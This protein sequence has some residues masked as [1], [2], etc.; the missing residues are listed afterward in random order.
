MKIGIDIDDTLTNTYELAFNYAEEY[1]INELKKEIKYV[2]R[3]KIRNRFTQTFHNWSEEEDRIFWDKYYETIVRNVRIKPF[4]KEVIDKLR[5]EE[6]EIYFITARHIS[7]KF[8][9]KK[10]TEEWLEKNEIK[11]EGIYLSIANKEEIIKE[12]NIDIF[13]D[14]N[15]TNCLNV[16]ETGIKTCI[17]D[18]LINCNFKDERIE[19]IYSWPHLYQVINRYKKEI[20]GSK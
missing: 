5:N 2:D 3:E 10:V 18:G 20:G 15:I 11:Y 19:R 4:A 1:T 7:N 9:I 17:M 16:L 12:K 14:D 13:I 8:D 6:N